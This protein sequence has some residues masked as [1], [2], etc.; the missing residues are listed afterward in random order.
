[1]NLKRKHSSVLTRDFFFGHVCLCVPYQ[2]NNLVLSLIIHVCLFPF[3]F[4]KIVSG[5]EDEKMWGIALNK[6]KKTY[7]YCMFITLV[8]KF[9]IFTSKLFSRHIIL[10]SQREPPYYFDARNYFQKNHRRMKH[11]PTD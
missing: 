11:P 9:V 6:T 3:L 8:Q 4:L 10:T 7:Y 5:R 2:T 1:M